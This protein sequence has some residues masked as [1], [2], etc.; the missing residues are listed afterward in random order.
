[1]LDGAIRKRIDP[2][3]RQT[4]EWLA[5]RGVGADTMT[6]IACGLGLLSAALVA[7]GHGWLA[8]PFLLASRLGDGLDGAIARATR[9][10][11]FG[12]FLDIVL[13]FVFYGAVPLAF[14]IADPARNGIAG[15]VLLFAFYVNGSSFLAFAV[16]AEK[17]RL[18]TDARGEKSFYF[19]TGLAEATETIAVFA[20]AC[21]CPDWFWWL[22][23]LFAA[24]TLYTAAAR[25]LFARR[26]MREER[27][28]RE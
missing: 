1:M 26:I 22:A 17:R 4:G 24:L 16:M 3:L 12:G 7:S 25:I 21:L 19:T 27:P 23:Y 8:L 2:H 28:G 15:A 18:T 11:D 14:V 13:D 10:T 5:E 20:I 9:K 6:L